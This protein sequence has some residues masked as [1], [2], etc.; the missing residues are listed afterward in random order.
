MPVRFGIRLPPCEAPQRVAEA[1]RQAEDGGFDDVWVPDSQLLAGVLLDPYV[2]LAVC[3]ERTRDVRL[4]VGVANP[5]TR[6]PTATAASILSLDELSGKRVI[7]GMGSGGSALT[8]IGREEE[9]LKGIH[10]SRR[11]ATRETVLLLRKLFEGKRIEFDGRPFQLRR[12]LR[13]IPIYVSATGPKMLRLAGAV[14]DGVIVQVG[15][16]PE[17]L[18]FA[19]EQ[20]RQGAEE[21]G[22][23]LQEMEVV[24]STFTSIHEDRRIAI[25]RVKPVV[26]WLYAAAPYVLDLSGIAYTRRLPSRPIY[27]DISHPYDLEDAVHE[28][29][30]YVSDG[31][32]EKLAL[33]GTPAE[34]ADQLKEVAGRFPIRQF[35]LRDYSTYQLPRE[36]IRVMAEEVIPR[37]R[38]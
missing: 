19:I 1:A 18:A 21:A 5:F 22:R 11:K 13:K 29:D 9:H 16:H 30:S 12:A 17:P 31:A 10:F 8:T 23:S 32:A 27:P 37:I 36:L 3:A 2:T 25:R 6:H 7:L 14:A 38:A 33:T 26:A 34:A 24:C 15:L 4:G 35:L 28:A 20:V